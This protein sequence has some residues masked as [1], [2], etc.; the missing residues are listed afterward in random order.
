MNKRLYSIAAI[1]CLLLT[2]LLLMGQSC[3]VT[4]TDSDGDGYAVEGGSCGPRDCDDTVADVSPGASEVCDDE[5]DNNCN[6]EVDEGCDEA[7]DDDSITTTTISGGIAGDTTIEDYDM[8]FVTI[9]GGTF[10]M[11]CSPNAND[12]N[13][14]ESPQHTVTVSSF[15]MSKYEITQR[16]WTAVMGSNPSEFSSC[17]NNCPVEEVSW[18]AVQEFIDTLNQQTGKNYRLPTEA[19]WEYAARAGTTTKYYCGDSESCLDDIAWYDGNSSDTPHPVGQKDPNDWGLYDMTG[20]VR[21]WCQDYFRLFYY[22]YSPSNNPQGPV[23][24]FGRVIRGGSWSYGA[25]GCRSS[26]RDSHDPSIHGYNLGFR[27]VLP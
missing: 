18:N 24:G 2:S 7:D 27:L 15:K 11:G 13:S 21:E 12:C 20:N 25:R 1:I 6:G 23:I 9:P 4:C 22:R 26:D 16:Q 3:Q 8:T 10:E 19:E 14:D 17:G 5:V